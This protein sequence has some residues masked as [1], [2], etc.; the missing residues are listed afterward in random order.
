M[1]YNPIKLQATLR[2]DEGK[3]NRGYGR[4]EFCRYEDAERVAQMKE[5][6]FSDKTRR[7]VQLARNAESQV[8]KLIFR[9]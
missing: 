6:F 7:T 4:V 1:E 3:R 5:V 8:Y 2:D 9:R